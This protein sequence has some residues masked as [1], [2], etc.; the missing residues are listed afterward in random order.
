MWHVHEICYP[1][2]YPTA[3]GHF[4]DN[5]IIPGAVLLDEAIHAI[6]GAAGIDDFTIRSAKFLDPVRPGETL[7]LRWERRPDGQTA[8]ECRARNPERL[9]LIG[10]LQ[11]GLGRL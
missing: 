3:A 4:P 2:D 11:I 6:G 8:F 10:L 5:P 9:V 7:E 1:L